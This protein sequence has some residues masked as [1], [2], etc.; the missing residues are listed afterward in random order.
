MPHASVECMTTSF[1]TYEVNSNWQIVKADAEFC[2]LF[3]G[4]ESSLIGCDVRELL[5]DDFKLDFRRYVARA[6]VG[7]GD[8][9]ATVPMMAPSGEALWCRHQLEPMLNDGRLTGFN[10]TIEPRRTNVTQ[11]PAGWW[12]WQGQ[13]PRLVW[14]SEIEQLA[15][16][17]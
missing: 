11:G 12:Q 14:N 13:A 9:V 5:R 4:T 15:Q 3:H 8:V 2:R 6:L 17:C 1:A 7:L 16:V 10:A